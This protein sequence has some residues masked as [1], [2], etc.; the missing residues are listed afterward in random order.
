MLLVS[1]PFSGNYKETIR[2][3]VL[4]NGEIKN[5]LPE[6]Y[7]GNPLSKKGS[8]VFYEYGWDFLDFLKDAGFSDAYM[9]AYYSILYG[10]LGDGNQFIFVAK[11]L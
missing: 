6:V 3:A 1:I 2:R 10:Y 8:L 11:K 9:L 7:H 4:E 5:L